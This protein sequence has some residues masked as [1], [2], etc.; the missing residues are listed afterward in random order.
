MI[1]THFGPL[2]TGLQIHCHPEASVLEG[3]L[4]AAFLAD[5]TDF[6]GE[7]NRRPGEPPN[8]IEVWIDGIRF[9][10][11]TARTERQLLALIQQSVAAWEQSGYTLEDDSEHE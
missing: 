3:E 8:H 11:E 10:D 9:V 1:K 7:H 6:F 5:N 4:V 2:P